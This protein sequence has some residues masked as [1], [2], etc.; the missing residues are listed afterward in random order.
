MRFRIRCNLKTAPNIGEVSFV[1]A[2]GPLLEW[3]V[4]VFPMASRRSRAPQ[5]SGPYA[6]CHPFPPTSDAPGC[7]D[8]LW[9]IVMFL[10]AVKTVQMM[11]QTHLHHLKVNN[12]SA[13]FNFWVNYSFNAHGFVLPLRKR[14]YSSVLLVY[15]FKLKN[16]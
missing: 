14:S 10:S 5:T 8:F 7:E 16:Y 15:F 6:L 3:N 12:F 13:N 11:K 1:S 4:P 2:I 9:I